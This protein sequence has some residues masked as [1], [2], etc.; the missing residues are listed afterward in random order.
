MNL[1]YGKNIHLFTLDFETE[2]N[3]YKLVYRHAYLS[4]SI[5]KTTSCDLKDRCGS[6]DKLLIVFRDAEVCVLQSRPQNYKL[7]KI[8]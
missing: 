6:Q 3:Q 4:R 5:L 8:I 2:V 1:N 7:C